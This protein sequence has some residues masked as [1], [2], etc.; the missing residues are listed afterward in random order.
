MINRRKL[1]L[2]TGSLLATKNVWAWT[3]DKA[4]PATMDFQKSP[5]SQIHSLMSPYSLANSDFLKKFDG[6]NE[7]FPH[8]VLWDRIGYLQKLGTSVSTQ[9]TDVLIIGGGM[10]GLC[11]AYFLQNKDCILLEQAPQLGGN[12]KGYVLNNKKTSIGAA[13][14]TIPD[15]NSPIERMLKDLGLDQAGQIEKQTPVFLKQKYFHDFKQSL[16]A[17]DLIYFERLQQRFL[18]IYENEFPEIPL[19]ADSGNR[20]QTLKW[21]AISFLDWLKAEWNGPVPESIQ[22][23]YQMYS[24]SSFAG[25]I[26][27]I[28][29]AQFLNFIT[30]ETQGVWAFPGGNAE[31]TERLFNKI[32]DKVQIKTSAFVADV[33]KKGSIYSTQY[34]LNSQLHTIESNHVIFAAPKLLADKVLSEDFKTQIAACE[35]IEYRSYLV[36]NVQLQKKI[37]LPGYDQFILDGE[38]P[39]TPTAMSPIKRGFPDLVN[40]QWAKE[41][42]TWTDLLT[43]Y[44]PLPYQGA[45]QFL[46]SPF[47]FEKHKTAIIK[48]LSARGISAELVQDIYISRWGH[49]LPV[50]QK[51]LLTKNVLASLYPENAQENFYFVGQDV[52]CNPAFEAAFETAWAA[53]QRIG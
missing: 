10:A 52:Y 35:K 9:K 41:Q 18:D 47:A 25:S 43:V 53:A 24:W 40:S 16:N 22:E 8:E 23:F 42:D 7:D 11:S 1:L 36:A 26:D 44:R 30:S 5:S 4:L 38:V 34:I 15:Q 51:G 13:Y 32:K 48:E 17:A 6:D 12:S 3:L 20:S 46:F 33:Q 28:S 45:R 49:A 27:E 39:E 21:D 2:G 50:A 37:Q 14:I 19:S 31:I 29:A